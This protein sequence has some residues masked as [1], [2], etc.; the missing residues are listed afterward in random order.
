MM[1]YLDR[2]LP[3]IHR[4][5]RFPGGPANTGCLCSGQ[6]DWVWPWTPIN[7]SEDALRRCDQGAQ[8]I[9]FESLIGVAPGVRPRCHSSERGVQPWSIAVSP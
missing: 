8:G 4:C 1:E 9:A 3:A 2:A 6:R 5:C 7:Q